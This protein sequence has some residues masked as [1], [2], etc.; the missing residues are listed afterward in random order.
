M[1]NVDTLEYINS[2]ILMSGH[3]HILLLLFM[4]INYPH[5]QFGIGRDIFMS[6]HIHNFHLILFYHLKK[7][8]Y[9]LYYIILQHNQHSNFYFPILLI[10][11][12]YIC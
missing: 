3:T 11:I 7:L 1:P 2:M 10:K 8:F 6:I 12:I 9:Q 4:I 5:W